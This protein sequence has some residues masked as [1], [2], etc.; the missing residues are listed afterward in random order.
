MYNVSKYAHSLLVIINISNSPLAILQ[1]KS[2]FKLCTRTIPRLMIHIAV[3]MPQ[4]E[5][6]M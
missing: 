5:S 2:F 6:I 3:A 1:E 4:K